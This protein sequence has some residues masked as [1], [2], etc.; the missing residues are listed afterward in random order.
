[1]SDRETH[2]IVLRFFIGLEKETAEWCEDVRG[3]SDEQRENLLENLRIDECV[4]AGASKHYA[5]DDGSRDLESFLKRE[6]IECP[7]D[8]PAF[9]KLRPLFRRARVQSLGRAIDRVEGKTAR[10]R[11]SFF[12]DAFAHTVAP[13]ARQSVTLGAMLTRFEQWLTKAGRTTGT[14]RTYEIPLRILRQL[15]GVNTALEAVTKEQIEQLFDLLRRV[16]ANQ[17]CPRFCE[18]RIAKVARAGAV[19]T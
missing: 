13:T 9:R 3:C 8:S 7:T 1:M 10:A 2:D 11:E 5:P 6:G 14:H 4:Y 18:N 19:V 15:I 17:R 12:R 16:P